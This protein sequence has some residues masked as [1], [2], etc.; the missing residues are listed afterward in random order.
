MCIWQ[1]K[2]ELRSCWAKDGGGGLKKCLFYTW[3]LI[4]NVSL[5]V[6]H[7]AKRS[8]VK[9]E[10]YA[11]WHWQS[12]DIN[13]RRDSTF[14]IFSFT[15]MIHHRDGVLLQTTADYQEHQIQ[16]KRPECFFSDIN[17]D[18]SN[19]THFLPRAERA[20]SVTADKDWHKSR[21]PQS[22][23]QFHCSVFSTLFCFHGSPPSL[24]IGKLTY[25]SKWRGT[26]NSTLSWMILQVEKML[27]HSLKD[28]RDTVHAIQENHEEIKWA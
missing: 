18:N 24:L 8:A 10:S 5:V 26:A 17:G 7:Y 28:E 6:C 14:I 19:D 13:L 9:S 3:G 11:F 4:I 15:C 25:Q 23:C 12:E 2:V 1:H 16:T 22:Q 20:G 27:T 21:W